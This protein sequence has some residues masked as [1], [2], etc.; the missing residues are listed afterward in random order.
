MPN[1]RRPF[2]GTFGLKLRAANELEQAMVITAYSDN[3]P[4]TLDGNHLWCLFALAGE[5]L[6]VSCLRCRR[7]RS[8][9]YADVPRTTVH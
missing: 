6:R 1:G 4:E 5:P 7:V 3:C 8:Y 2:L 9:T